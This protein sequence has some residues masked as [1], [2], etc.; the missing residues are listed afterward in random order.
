MIL[1]PPSRTCVIL[2]GFPRARQRPNPCLFL[3]LQTAPRSVLDRAC[4]S[5]PPVMVSPTL[6][7]SASGNANLDVLKRPASA[8][9]SRPSSS[10]S[11]ELGDRRKQ[12]PKPP[13]IP[14]VLQSRVGKKSNSVQELR[15]VALEGDFKVKHLGLLGIL[16]WI[17]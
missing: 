4:S 3:R 7:A 10:R 1:S 6:G 12:S 16:A 9:S 8:S 13:Q 5:L 15:R 2:G 14:A 17:L 11:T